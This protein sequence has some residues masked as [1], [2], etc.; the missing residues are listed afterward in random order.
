[1]SQPGKKFLIIDDSAADRALVIREIR[2]DF[3]ET[4]LVEIESPEEFR[5]ALAAGGFDL[6]IVD[7]ALGWIDGLELMH[8]V[9]LAYRNVPVIMFT[10]TAGE[11]I[12]VEA[13]KSGVDDYI[14]KSQIAH[15]RLPHAVRSALDRASERAEFRRMETRFGALFRNI[16]VG[17]CRCTENGTVIEANPA[18]HDLLG[19]EPGEALGQTRL[20]E[21]FGDTK[22]AWKSARNGASAEVCIR[23]GDGSLR[24][25]ILRV[26]PVYEQGVDEQGVD[27]RGGGERSG[28]LECA[29]TDIT[30]LKRAQEERSVLLS[31]LYHRV[32]NNLQMLISLVISLATRARDPDMTKALDDLA[33]RIHSISL[34][35]ERLYRSGN[36][37]AVDLHNFV[38]ELAATLL[39]H[40]AIELRM[41]LDDIVVPVPRAIPL[42]L[43]AN[44]LVLN[45][46][47]HAFPGWDNPSLN[48]TL[49]RVSVDS[50]ELTIQDN[51]V[52]MDSAVASSSTGYGTRL[53]QSLVRQAG[54][55]ID[56]VSA[57]GAGT[58]ISIR[59]PLTNVNSHGA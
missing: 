53:V 13:M 1:M 6:V 57:A 9:K 47:K 39:Q 52:G 22:T 29:L 11:E 46:V 4:T 54:A 36:F 23:R 10:G 56:V 20:P 3:P 41:D 33:T 50:A 17:L 40:T 37:T 43:V 19:I 21:L 16:P 59:F 8:Q 2:R 14:L 12:A 35:Q 15:S 44:E 42:G 25:A 55:E 48:I 30:D 18:L 51:G 27:E 58:R 49:K 38:S 28:E 5:E 45:A 26:R 31:E 24:H 32:N 34:V 7:Y